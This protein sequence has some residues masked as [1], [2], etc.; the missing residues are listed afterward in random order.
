ME[1]LL[2][3][4][5]DPKRRNFPIYPFLAFIHH[6][7][8]IN[9]PPKAPIPFIIIIEKNNYN[10][11]VSPLC[12]LCHKGG[13]ILLRLNV[14]YVPILKVERRNNIRTHQEPKGAL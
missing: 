8:W 11:E 2:F 14:E 10:N 12:G 5:P 6:G 3:W 7:P 4:D 13:K 1:N 9:P